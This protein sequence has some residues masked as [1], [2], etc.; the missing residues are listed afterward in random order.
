[1]QEIEIGIVLYKN[2]MGICDKKSPICKKVDKV[3]AQTIYEDELNRW[4]TALMDW[5]SKCFKGG[6]V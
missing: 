2:E 4:V 6:A 5:F 1:M 3:H